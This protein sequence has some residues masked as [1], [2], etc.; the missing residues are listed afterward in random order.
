VVP[1]RGLKT[2]LIARQRVLPLRSGRG[3]LTSRSMGLVLGGT[4]RV[5]KATPPGVLGVA[6]VL[7]G[8]VSVTP[9]G[10]LALCG[11]RGGGVPDVLT[12]CPGLSPR[13]ESTSP[14]THS[15][16]VM[17]PP[18]R[19]VGAGRWV[20][21]RVVVPRLGGLHSR[22]TGHGARDGVRSGQPSRC[23]PRTSGCRPTRPWR[24]HA[25]CPDQPTHSGGADQCCPPTLS[26][27]CARVDRGDA[28][29]VANVDRS[30]AV[31]VPFSFVPRAPP[32]AGFRRPSGSGVRVRSWRSSSLAPV[33]SVDRRRSG[34]RVAVP[35]R[36]AGSLRSRA[37][38]RVPV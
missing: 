7:P 32:A 34:P 20:H 31:S 15:Q 16:W 1:F 2:S 10:R 9:A 4:R 23:R 3:A 14:S 19:A 21:G 22:W 38:G 36:L 28:W 24:S 8:P 18:D 27:I 13:G 12:C 30:G 37:V 6:A 26:G 25:S 5:L 35:P 11:R 33:C 29:R 17:R